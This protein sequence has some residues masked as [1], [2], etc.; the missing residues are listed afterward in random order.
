MG[1]KQRLLLIDDVEDLG[2]KGEVVEVK[3]GFAR[4]FLLPKQ[5]ATFAT[6]HTLRMQT[7]LQEEREKLAVSD[8]VESEGLAK[9]ISK[10]PSIQLDV[11]VDPEGTL[12]G[13]VTS[14]DIAKKLLDEN[15]DVDKKYIKLAKPIKETGTFEVPIH[16]K[17]GIEA[18]ITVIVKGEGQVIS[19]VVEKEEEKVAEEPAAKE[20]STEETKE[21]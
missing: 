2:R 11:N 6:N 16:L 15:L 14:T 9:K 21:G 1:Q 7:R 4:N 13:S 19:P 10:I 8:K 3:S 17:E 5:K 12:Y 20:E 18:L